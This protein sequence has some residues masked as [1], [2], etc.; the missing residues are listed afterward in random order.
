MKSPSNRLAKF[1]QLLSIFGFIWIFTSPVIAQ[2]RQS[3]ISKITAEGSNRFSE[4]QISLASGLKTGQPADDS[5]LSAAAD[6]LSK[7]GAFSEVTYRYTTSSGKMTVVF[8][9]VDES[10][11]MLCTFDNFIWVSTD[12]TDRAVREEVPLYDGR[13]PVDGDI[14][15]A[16]ATALEHL[17]ARHH[18]TA[19]VNYLPASRTL[20]TAP[21]EF[22]YSASGNLPPVASVEFNGDRLT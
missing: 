21:T 18:I 22:R 20:G 10:K 13:V 14:V 6:L 11:T 16:V 3:I 4:S 1:I 9:V 19:T 5:V 12:E 17:L 7:S 2:S 15:Q 8:K